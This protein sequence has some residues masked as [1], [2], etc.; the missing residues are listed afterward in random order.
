MKKTLGMRNLIAGGAVIVA[1]GLGTATVASA[2][3]SAP[4]STTSTSL[5]PPTTGAMNPA[6]MSHG[7]GETLLTG[8]ALTSATTAAQAA[9]ANA[10]VIRAE[11]NSSGASAYEVH[12]R[13]ADGSY[14]TV[15]LNDSFAAVATVDGF[16]PGPAGSG[17]AGPMGARPNGPAPAGAAPTASN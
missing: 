6:T 16:G 5:T 4:A 1:A 3:T 10:T 8:T 11:T 12:M 14:V 13:K 17:A 7:P 15:E 2:S 9:V